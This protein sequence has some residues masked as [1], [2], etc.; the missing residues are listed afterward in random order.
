ME[1]AVQANSENGIQRTSPEKRRAV[2][3]ALREFGDMSDYSIAEICQAETDLVSQI[4]QQRDSGAISDD[5]N[6]AT[7]E[8]KR[9]ADMAIEEL[10]SI[11]ADSPYRGDAM[12]KIEKWLQENK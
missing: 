5:E 9:L 6:E 12:E 8:P 11:L 7:S 10:A 4:R 2:K 1:R 3:V